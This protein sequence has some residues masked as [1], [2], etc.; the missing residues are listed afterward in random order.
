VADFKIVRI[1]TDKDAQVT[2]DGALVSS[3][4]MLGVDGAVAAGASDW[5]PTK[6]TQLTFF[7]YR[8][9]RKTPVSAGVV[10]IQ[11]AMELA[12]DPDDPDLDTAY[13][14]LATLN[15]STPRLWTKEN[16]RYIRAVVTTPEAGGPGLQVGLVA[17]DGV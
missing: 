14:L 15:A 5:M 2:L 9:D 4:R 17:V 10:Q 7:L 3:K 11:V 8:Q 16:W 12:E 13:F 6:A 1:P